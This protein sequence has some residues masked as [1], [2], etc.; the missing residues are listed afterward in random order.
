MG[1]GKQCRTREKLTIEEE[2]SR[3]SG[4]GGGDVGG[5]QAARRAVTNVVEQEVVREEELRSA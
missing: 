5:G 2:G 4:M 1:R 3:V